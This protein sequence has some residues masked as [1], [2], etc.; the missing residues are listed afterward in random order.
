MAKKRRRP[1]NRSHPQGSS[2]STVRTAEPLAEDGTSVADRNGGRSDDRQAG[3]EP[4]APARARA[5][6][7]QRTRAEKKELAR[8]QREEIRRQMR[9]A[10]RL[11]QLLWITGAAAAIAVAVFLITGGDDTTTRPDTLPGELTTEAP[12]PANADQAAAR[13]EAI[14]LPAEGSAMHEHADI[15]VFVHGERETIPVDVG[16][17]DTGESLH[18][19]TDDGVVH[20]ESSQVREFT[21]GEF[22]DVW[23]VRLSSTCLGGYCV[24]GADEL[25]VFKDGERVNGPIRQVVLDDQSVIVVTFGAPEELPDPIPSTFDF[26]TVQP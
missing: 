8:Q 19:H 6:G 21:L 23:G 26:S 20:I 12:W 5:A 24:S 9:R 18:T 13:A 7:P 1:Q 11:R 10:Q 14:G 15:Q 16:V 2:R 17:A 25:L 3:S 4:P 22:F